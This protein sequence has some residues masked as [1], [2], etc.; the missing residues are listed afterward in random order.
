MS[1]KAVFWIRIRRFLDLPDLSLF[2][3]YPDLVPDPSINK[4]RAEEP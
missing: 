4:Q 2:C 1:L 3:T